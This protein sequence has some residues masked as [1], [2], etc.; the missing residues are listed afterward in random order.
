MAKIGFIM[1]LIT[2]IFFLYKRCGCGRKNLSIHVT[3]EKEHIKYFLMSNKKIRKVWHPQSLHFINT[4]NVHP[5]REALVLRRWYNEYLLSD[6]TQTNVLPISFLTSEELKSSCAQRAPACVAV[7]WLSP[8]RGHYFAGIG[9]KG[10]RHFLTPTV[11]RA[12]NSAPQAWGKRLD[13][14]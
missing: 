5:R 9:R 6:K 13:L 4:G 14:S 12:S 11:A 10:G 2:P 3:C 1:M 8:G 7:G